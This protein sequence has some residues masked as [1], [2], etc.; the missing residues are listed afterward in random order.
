M[1]YFDS[2]MNIK[3]KNNDK[4]SAL[5]FA[6]SVDAIIRLASAVPSFVPAL[7]KFIEDINFQY[8]DNFGFRFKPWSNNMHFS[9]RRLIKL[10]WGIVKLQLHNFILDLSRQ[11]G[12]SQL[13]LSPI[14]R[15]AYF[16]T[17]DKFKRLDWQLS[18]I[19]QIFTD[20][21][22]LQFWRHWKY[23][24]CLINLPVYTAHWWRKLPKWQS[25]QIKDLL[26]Y[27]PQNSSHKFHPHT[28]F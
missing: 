19:K 5:F 6:V 11:N 2:N 16:K 27:S 9:F 17:I 7:L 28:P 3:Y 22:I 12:R 8:F 13:E 10:F 1:N 20:S 25:E 4:G 24:F 14:R 15:S 21:T 23:N 18:D 26:T